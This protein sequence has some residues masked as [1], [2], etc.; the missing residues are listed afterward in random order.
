MPVNR[1]GASIELLGDFCDVTRHRVLSF[2]SAMLKR[3]PS[4]ALSARARKR[5][6]NGVSTITSVLDFTDVSPDKTELMRV[7]HTNVEDPSASRKSVVPVPSEPQAGEADTEVWE[8]IEVITPA[9]NSTSAQPKQ[10]RGKRGNNSV[11]DSRNS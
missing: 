5:K 7:W 9:S 11:S 4:K 3:G 10:K 6:R 1:G 2:V 8:D